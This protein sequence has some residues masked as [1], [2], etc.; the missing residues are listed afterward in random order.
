MSQ[1]H[2]LQQQ[3][4]AFEQGTFLDSKCFYFYDWFCRDA[5]LHNKA[6]QLM[7]KAKKF[8]AL[9][10]IDATS[11]Y[12]FFKNN[13]PLNGKL[14]DDF[15]ICD[16]ATGDVLYTIVPACGHKHTHNECCIWSHLNNFKEPHM[17]ASSWKQMLQQL[18]D[19]GAS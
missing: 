2:T 14:Y 18:K 11:T 13:C 16:V 15:R 3:L 19:D 12:V 1:Q 9:M 4:E 17:K 8:A 10:N 6:K 5:S 7:T